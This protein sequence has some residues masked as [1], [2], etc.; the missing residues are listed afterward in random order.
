MLGQELA[1]AE[2][3]QHALIG[4]QPGIARRHCAWIGRDVGVAEQ[5]WIIAEGARRQRDVAV[6]GVKRRAV[7]ADAVVHLVEAGVEAG[8]GRRARCRTT[9]VPLEQRTLGGQ[10]VGIRRLHNRMAGGGHAIAA[11]LVACDQ[12]NIRAPGFSGHSRYPYPLWSNA[13]HGT[14]FR[15]RRKP[16]MFVNW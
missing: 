3:R 15:G 14:E 9:I 11:P 8:A 13:A 10:R 4:F 6:A 2:A 12:K 5:R 7:A 1:H 16:D